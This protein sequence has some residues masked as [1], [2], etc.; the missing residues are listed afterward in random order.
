MSDSSHNSR[1]PSS[2]LPIFTSTLREKD[3]VCGMSVD[4]ATAAVKLLY[5]G[6]TY[7]FCSARCAERF[8]KE[9]E[10]FLAAPE[11]AGMH[12]NHA[13]HATD[14]PAPS[15]APAI[16][17]ETALPERKNARY[18]CPMHPQ[19]VQI[20]PGTCPICGMALEPK[21]VTLDDLPDIEYVHMKRRFWISAVLTL[22]VFVLAMAEMLPNFH[23]VFSPA[24]SLWIQFILATPV[25]LWGGLP[26][27][28]R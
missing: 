17:D 15:A 16:K 9:P 21:E 14:A 18:T 22:P 4:P 28:Q 19:I 8:S 2:S 3:P 1:V 13:A 27:F 5:G 24:T 10:K 7:Y 6:K 26:F 12:K 11:T 23:Q 25:V 20:G